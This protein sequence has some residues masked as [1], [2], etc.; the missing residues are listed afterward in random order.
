MNRS[1]YLKTSLRLWEDLSLQVLKL[2]IERCALDEGKEGATKL[3]VSELINMTKQ[4]IKINNIHELHFDRWSF[5][6]L[7]RIYS[8]VVQV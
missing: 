1:L 4:L 7:W 8:Q 6:R 3:S 2:A 5:N